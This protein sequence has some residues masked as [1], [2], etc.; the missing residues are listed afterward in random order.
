MSGPLDRLDDDA[1]ALLE[2]TDMPR[3]VSPMLATL[4]DERFSSGD[5]IYER[6][7]DGIR[8]LVFRGRHG[9]SLVSRNG[10]AFDRAFPELAT[11]AEDSGSSRIVADGEIVTFRGNVTSFSRL[12]RRIGLTDPSDQLIHEVSVK[13]YL[14]DIIYCDGFDTT[15]LP[16][17]RR[18]QLLK[19]AFEWGDPLRWTP[20]RNASGEAYYAEACDKGWE[21]VIAKR[22]DSRYVHQRSRDWLK[23]KC[24]A[25][26]ELVIGGY[27]DP[28]GE[29][30]GFGALL[31]GYYEDGNLRYA[32]RVGT[33]FDDELLEDLSRRLERLERKT[34]PFDPPP[35]DDD[36]V[37]WVSPRLVGEIGFTEWTRAG[38]LRH[39]RF[40]GLR[41]DKAPEDVVRE[42]AGEG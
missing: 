39:P 40:I 7:L 11:A 12:Q 42:R 9:P 24:T 30:K 31:L 37:H 27:T 26:Q 2:R 22:A 15:A 20:H 4:T 33:G 8:T 41:P 21:G 36:H 13:L 3:S 10:Q 34:S 38:R 29:R 19:D 23:F 5:W 14:F 16:L 1:R 18:K 32:G 17:R 35:E 6:K 25:G 28:G